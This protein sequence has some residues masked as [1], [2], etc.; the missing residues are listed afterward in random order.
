MP[1][2][3]GAHGAEHLTRVV[4]GALA[5]A[6]ALVAACSGPERP[7]A[8]L[9]LRFGVLLAAD[10][11][12]YFVIRAKGFDTAHGLSITETV[13]RGGPAVLAGLAAGTLDAG[14]PDSVPVLNASRAGLVPDAVTVVGAVAFTDPQHLALALVVGEG[15][16]GWSSLAGQ[17]VAIN[18]PDT[19]GD[20]AVRERLRQEGVTRTRFVSI[21]SPN[22]GLAIAG[23]NVAAAAMMEPFI[24]QSLLRGDGHVLDW[25]VGGGEPFPQSEEAVIAVSRAYRSAHPDAVKAFLRAHLDAVAWIQAHEREAR[26]L[27]SQRLGLP[28]DIGRRMHLVRFARDA[29]NDPALLGRTREVMV[30]LTPLPA[31]VSI[32]RLY[33]E[34]LLDQVLAEGRPR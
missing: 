25:I 3:T 34:T 2:R 12:P 31:P 32:G 5:A 15:I 28:S 7:R 8:S 30:G 27:F 6:L 17:A 18:Q 23:G 16:T 11:L 24:T 10:Q 21:A 9:Q 33:D 26:D 14:Y 29:R 1:V 4:L 20:I 13:L 19:I 22:Q